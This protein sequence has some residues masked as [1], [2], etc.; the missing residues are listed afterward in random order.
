MTKFC[1]IA[2]QYGKVIK[3]ND[4]AECPELLV[5]YIENC[6]YR[7]K[8]KKICKSPFILNEGG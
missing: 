6:R 2:Y 8:T 5:K 3:L 7:H 4:D 1:K